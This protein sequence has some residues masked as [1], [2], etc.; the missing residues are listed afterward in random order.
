MYPINRKLVSVFPAVSFAFFTKA[1]VLLSL[2][3]SLREH[4]YDLLQI[5]M[6][7]VP[8]LVYLL[9]KDGVDIRD[10]IAI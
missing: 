4:G 8:C 1:H 2:L 5:R 3:K 10:I 9:T 7:Y 6:C